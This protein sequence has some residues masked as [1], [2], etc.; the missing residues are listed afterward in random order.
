MVVNI[1]VAVNCFGAFGDIK[2]YCYGMPNC[3]FC[4]VQWE[5]YILAFWLF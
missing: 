3:M 5:Y 1:L 4:L 2:V